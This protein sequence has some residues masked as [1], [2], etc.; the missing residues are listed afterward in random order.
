MKFTIHSSL[1][2]DS[3]DFREYGVNELTVF[4]LNFRAKADMDSH[5][6]VAHSWESFCRDLDN[7]NIILA[8]FC[9]RVDCEELIKKE[10]AKEEGTVDSGAPAMGAKSLCIPFEQP[11]K[12]EP[13]STCIHTKCT[14]APIAYTL[15]GRSY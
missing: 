13:G 3:K 15:F 10:S 11:Q 14:S 1:C 12:L 2:K 5:I 6:S 4:I 8:P 9:G 7:N